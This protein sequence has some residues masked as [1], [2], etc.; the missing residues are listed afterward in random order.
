MATEEELDSV[1]PRL[2]GL[3]DEKRI[4]AVWIE[5]PTRETIARFLKITDL[6]S[7]I[8]DA[9]DDL[10]IG[11][12]VPAHLLMPL[13]PGQRVCGPAVTI[14]YVGRGGTPGAHYARASRPLLADRDLYG[15]GQAGDV[16]VFDCGGAASTSVM[17]NLSALWAIRL[18]IAGCVVDGGVRDI[19]SIRAT[20]PPVWSRGRTP[21]TGRHRLEAVEINGT[22]AICGA[23]VRP[24]DLLAADDTGVCVVPLENV[25]AVIAHCEAAAVAE[26]AVTALIKSGATATEVTTALKPERW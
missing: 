10:G 18:G 9:L 4:R 13:A 2:L 5:R 1:R 20:G 12:A 23:Q 15:V 24:G 7:T 3:I 14:R 8:S 22:V 26:D 17:G 25:G 19:A 6:T 16:A 21:S 11:A